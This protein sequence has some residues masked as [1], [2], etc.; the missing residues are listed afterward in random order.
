MKSPIH[1]L[2]LFLIISLISSCASNDD[3][4]LYQNDVE[5]RYNEIKR[6][7]NKGKYNAAAYDLGEFSSNHP[8]SKFAV[9]AELLRIFASYK[10]GEL[11]LAETLS[12]TFID[13]H[14]KH[15]NVDYAKYMLAMSHFKQ[16]SSSKHD[17]SHVLLAIEGFK[18]LLREHP[19]SGYAE[20][21]NQRLQK[22]Y[23]SLAEHELAIGKFYFKKERYVAAANRFQVVAKDYQTSP[24]IEEALYLLAASYDEMGMTKDASQIARLLE[25]NYPSSSWSSKAKDYR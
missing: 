3:T 10:G 24:A 25:H 9:Q 20:E 5:Q 13:R 18:R 7:V 21:G 19:D 22:L 2:Y 1:F 11:I 15:A 16:K 8:Y 6:D 4:T 12:T 23:N 17:P 14:P